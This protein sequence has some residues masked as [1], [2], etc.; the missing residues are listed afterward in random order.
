MLK[1]IFFLLLTVV[2][3]QT[4]F[5]Q[6]SEKTSAKN[7]L[8]YAFRNYFPVGVAVS[9]RNLTGKD[10]A[11][12]VQQFNS[13]TP[14]NAFKF[15][16]IHPEENRYNWAAADSITA[17][18]KAHYLKIRGHNFCWH[19]QTP[20][21]LFKD[22]EGKQ[23]SKEV[24]LKR[25]KEHIYTVVN[26]YKNQVYAW[27]VV[28]EALDDDSTKFLRNSMW[29]KICGEDY[30]IKAY[31]YVHAADPK[32]ILFY[33]DYKTEHPERRERIY[34]LLKQL[35][36]AGVP[37]QAVGLQAHWNLEDPTQKELITTIERFHSLGLQVQITELD[38]SVLP[39]KKKRD[40]VWLKQP[41]VYTPQLEQKQIEQYTSVFNIFKRYKGVLTGVT[42]WNLSDKDTWLDQTPSAKGKKNYP[43]LFD[44]NLKPK[45]VF[46][47]L[48][49]YK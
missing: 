8:K 34:K 27:D 1:K 31:Q 45:K 32:A 44:A 43:L 13:L 23:V 39:E 41:D 22:K 26:R 33:N 16:P 40:S 49:K 10:S 20:D 19:E 9:P 37:V 38:I 15:G 42:F 2:F 18:A 3:L 7:S 5:A 46:Y 36:D 11:L 29:Y 14:E 47:E 4:S 25:L 6:T 48:V 35:K 17:F 24:L 12:I 21:W 28:N 30:I